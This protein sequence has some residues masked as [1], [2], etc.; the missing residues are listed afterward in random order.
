M[1][2]WGSTSPSPCADGAEGSLL[3]REE[4]RRCRVHLLTASVGVVRGVGSNSQQQPFDL[5]GQLTMDVGQNVLWLPVWKRGRHLEPPTLS[6]M[7]ERSDLLVRPQPGRLAWLEIKLPR[8]RS[9]LVETNTSLCRSG[10]LF[11]R[12]VNRL[13]VRPACSQYSALQFWCYQTEFTFFTSR[14]QIHHDCYDIHS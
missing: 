5:C 9:S 13:P 1:V 3:P 10:S 8:T 2:T 4:L 7:E 14:G 12:Q 11:L 6:S